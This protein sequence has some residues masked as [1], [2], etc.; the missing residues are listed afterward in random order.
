[1]I[2]QP[3]GFDGFLAELAQMSE[4]DLT[5]ET[6]MAALQDKYDIVR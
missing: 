5:D 4:A 3:S 1:M 6:V 2:F